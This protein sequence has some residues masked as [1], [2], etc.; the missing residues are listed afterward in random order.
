MA[1]I[2]RS[3]GQS[4]SHAY[5]VAEQHHLVHGL[6]LKLRVEQTSKASKMNIIRKNAQGRNG[7]QICVTAHRCPS[8]IGTPLSDAPIETATRL[9]LPLKPLSF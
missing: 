4:R 2:D 5:N 9:E 3:Q 7:I 8:E 6:T 1:V